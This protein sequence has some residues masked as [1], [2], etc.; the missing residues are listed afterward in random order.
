MGLLDSEPGSVLN[1]VSTALNDTVE[2]Y[3]WTL[4]ITGKALHP[5]LAPR[6]TPA[7][8]LGAPGPAA[9]PPLAA[10]GMLRIR[11]GAGR[12]DRA[13]ALVNLIRTL[14]LPPPLDACPVFL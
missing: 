9:P 5:R 6:E 3:R 14:I 11:G 4:S 10:V 8:G 1:V 7:P 2:L 13:R 12:G